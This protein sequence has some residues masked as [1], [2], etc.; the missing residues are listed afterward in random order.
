[1][2]VF[3]CALFIHVISWYLFFIHM[4]HIVLYRSTAYSLEIQRIPESKKITTDFQSFLQKYEVKT[5]DKSY[6]YI[7]YIYLYICIVLFIFIYI[8]IHVEIRRDV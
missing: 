7:L 1:M 4:I 5:Y 3:K 2:Y 8:F 6:I